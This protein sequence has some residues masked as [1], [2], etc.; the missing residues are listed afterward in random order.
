MG[1]VLPAAVLGAV[2]VLA[3]LLMRPVAEPAPPEPANA[4]APVNQVAPAPVTGIRARPQAEQLAAA[5]ATAFGGNA[6]RSVG[7]NQYRY[8]P[9]GLIWIGDRA[10]LVSAGT[11]PE[12]CHACA[13]TLAV[14]Y[15]AAEGDG[16][17][18]TGTWLEGGGFADWGRPPEWRF[19]T[20]LSSQPMLRTEGGGGNQG[21]FCTGVKYYEFADGGPR[22]LV[23]VQTG[24]SDDGYRVPENGVPPTEAE[25]AMR[26]IVPGRSFDMVYTIQRNALRG[27][28]FVQ[29]RSEQL[30]E[31]YVLRDGRYRLTPG[32]TRVPQC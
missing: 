4:A 15:L 31:H 17:R 22:E 16:F 13:G 1:I 19:S 26:N 25:G 9:A 24:Y 3:Y 8:R 21:I 2:G 14:H 29:G 20:D 18:L 32:P 7:D 23:D 27:G 5:F 12:D 30:T 28:H 11:N 10:V 6:S